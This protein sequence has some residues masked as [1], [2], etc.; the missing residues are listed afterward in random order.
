MIATA[1][2]ITS[3]ALVWL[4]D[5]MLTSGQYWATAALFFTL[6]FFIVCMGTL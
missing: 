4:G 3:A 1:T 2:A 5:W 6:G